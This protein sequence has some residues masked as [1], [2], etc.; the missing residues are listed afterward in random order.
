MGVRPRNNED[1]KYFEDEWRANKG[2][3]ILKEPEATAIY[4]S[5]ATGG[6]FILTVKRKSTC[7]KINE[8][9]F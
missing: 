7:E 9:E 4:G 5:R 1:A 3:E 2:E 8:I 6:V